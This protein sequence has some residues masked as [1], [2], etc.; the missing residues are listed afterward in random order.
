MTEYD[1]SEEG[2]KRYLETQQ[3]ISRWVD[4]TNSHS[5]EYKS[6]FGARSDVGTEEPVLKSLG[7]SP[8]PSA[9]RSRPRPHEYHG[10]T[11]GSRK[12]GS[13]MKRS[14]SVHRPSPRTRVDS[15]DSESTYY[16][17][18]GPG[19]MPKLPGPV[20]SY[21][22]R[23]GV[24]GI[25][26]RQISHLV[27][28][29]SRSQSQQSHSRHSGSHGNRPSSGSNQSRSTATRGR[30]LVPAALP[31]SGPPQAA[32][33]ARSSSL[34]RPFPHNDS[35]ALGHGHAHGHGH[36]HN[37][38]GDD[39]DRHRHHHS[40][41]HSNHHPHHH[42]HH[43][44]PRSRSTG[45]SVSQSHSQSTTYEISSPTYIAPALG[46]NRPVIVPYSR[47]PGDRRYYAP[48]E[49]LRTGY[50]YTIIPQKG[51]VVKVMI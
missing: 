44:R 27:D 6:P 41:H 45:P 35:I 48:N 26:P 8:A 31:V 5:N 15:T 4:N 13:D 22:S 36:H 38:H 29:I 10:S 9:I 25:P 49:M 19:P 17:P 12:G 33:M 50:G 14:S 28:S 11:D 2:Y 42:H 23:A 3:R 18:D 47:P 37:H 7:A 1:Y 24:P 21:P 32:S 39:R 34:P 20:P 46:N 40:S 30:A 43:H 51:A 16:D